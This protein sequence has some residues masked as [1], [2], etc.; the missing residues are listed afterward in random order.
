MSTRVK[1]SDLV[2]AGRL[3]EIRPRSNASMYRV[4]TLEPTIARLIDGP[5][6]VG[7]AEARTMP[8]LKSQLENFMLG[9]ILSASFKREPKVEF[10]RLQPVRMSRRKIVWELRFTPKEDKDHLRLLGCF[11][12]LDHF[13]GLLMKPRDKI[14]FNKDIAHTQKIW[15]DLIP[16]SSPIVSEKI[17][18]Y[19]SKPVL[20]YG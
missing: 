12:E 14:D 10:R 16:A 19:I 18:D 7:S 8:R 13:V 6:E 2:A 4:I 5:W 15:G 9:K 17:N 20:F 11:A 1:I 3:V